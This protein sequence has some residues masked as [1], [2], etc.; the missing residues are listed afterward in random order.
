MEEQIKV[1][2]LISGE[3][4]IATVS[5]DDTTT[6]Y[7][8]KKPLSIGIDQQAQRLVFVPFMPYTDAKD[9]FEI[10]KRHVQFPSI[11]QESL[12]NDYV[13]A[14]GGGPQIVAP[15]RQLIRPIK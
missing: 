1:L 12:I 11:P 7:L 4:I 15:S 5:H 10:D 13:N 6:T 8:V 14:V 3:E 2:R 9:G